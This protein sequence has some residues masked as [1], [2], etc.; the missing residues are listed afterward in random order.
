MTLQNHRAARVHPVF[1][2]I[3]KRDGPNCCSLAWLASQAQ[4]CFSQLEMPTA[5]SWGRT[6]EGLSGRIFFQSSPPVQPEA[7]PVWVLPAFLAQGQ[8]GDS[9]G[10]VRSLSKQE[11][12]FFPRKKLQSFLRKWSFQTKPE[13]WNQPLLNVTLAIFIGLPA[14]SDFHF[15]DPLLF[16]LWHRESKASCMPIKHSTSELGS[17]PLPRLS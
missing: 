14:K 7:G 17:Q 10:Q 15:E 1:S 9:S 12:L 16:L 3:S 8:T 4:G 5:W 11:I 2:R 13:Q 6:G